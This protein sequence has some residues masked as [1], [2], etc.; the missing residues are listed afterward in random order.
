MLISYHFTLAGTCDRISALSWV[1]LAGGL[2]FWFGYMIFHGELTRLFNACSFKIAVF[3]LCLT[4]NK[5]IRTLQLKNVWMCAYVHIHTNTLQL[6]AL[7]HPILH[8]DTL[9]NSNLISQEMTKMDLTEVKFIVR[10]ILKRKNTPEAGDTL[11]Q[12]GFRAHS[13]FYTN[14]HKLIF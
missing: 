12:P 10:E 9:P 3:S 1:T 14:L 11:A 13:K 7:T 8:N 5:Y 2:V 6:P 4:K